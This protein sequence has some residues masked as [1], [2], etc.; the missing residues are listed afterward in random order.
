MSLQFDGCA[1]E[2]LVKRLTD[3]AS[4]AFEFEVVL[5]QHSVEKYRRVGGRFQGAV[6]IEDGGSPGDVVGLPFARLAVGVGQWNGLLVDAAG[7]SVH[8]SFVVVVVEHLQFVAGI[9]GAGRG[10]N[11][12]AVAAGLAG[13]GHVLGNSPFDMKLIVLKAALGL[14]VAGIFA[15]GDDAGGDG[16]LRGS[17]AILGRDPLIEILAVEEHN[18]VGGRGSTRSAGGYDFGLGLPDLRVF[19]LGSGGL[20]SKCGHGERHEK[21]Q[22]SG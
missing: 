8:I 16:P 2:L 9:A 6:L 21:K 3:V 22:R 10:K 11:D 17:G 1:V 19:G 12:S 4:L 14:D 13:A 15:D 7:L 20:L 5:Y 18:R